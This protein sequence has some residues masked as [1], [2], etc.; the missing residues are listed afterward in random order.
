MN[1][2]LVVSPDSAPP[3]AAPRVVRRPLGDEWTPAAL[4][5]P[6]DTGVLCF[7]GGRF[8]RLSAGTI[9]TALAAFDGTPLVSAVEARRHPLLHRRSV[10]VLATQT[11]APARDGERI[12]LEVDAPTGTTLMKIRA[13]HP[14]RAFFTDWSP[15][16]R[17]PSCTR[18][19][20][21]F[22]GARHDW[23]L[24]LSAGDRWTLDFRAP[25]QAESF[26]VLLGADGDG[27][28]EPFDC[29]GY[30]Y[31][32]P[33]FPG[34]VSEW[35]SGRT[36]TGRQQF[37]PFRE[38]IDA[39]LICDAARPDGMDYH[40]VPEQEALCADD[41]LDALRLELLP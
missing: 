41:P 39:F 37:P 25:A 27:L 8:P 5:R 30:W 20:A 34:Y 6:G 23:N 21:E 10:R 15:W 9:E 22:E 11:P 1:Y 2:T 38:I 36:I 4:L 17:V 35:T 13:S 24:R 28:L 31:A 14:D 19:L 3:I 16:Y 33:T 18:D 40:L 29:A 7:V 12:Q 26:E 32:D